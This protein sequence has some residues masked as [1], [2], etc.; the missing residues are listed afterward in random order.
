MEIATV[1]Q[2]H[3]DP[4]TVIDTVHS[5]FEYA[6]NNVLLLING[7][8]WNELKDIDL[9]VSKVK[10]FRHDVPKSP[11]RN[12]ALG[13]SLA[14]ENWDSDWFCYTEYDAI[15]ASDRFKHNLRMA[16][17]KGVWM[18]GNCGHV[19]ECQMPLVE[20]LIGE[21]FRS[22]YYLLGCCLFFHRDFM[23]KLKEINFFDRFLFLTNSFSEG[24]FPAYTGYDI[25][26]HMY[27]TLCR[28]F[29][30]NVGVFATWDEIKQEWH[31]AYEHFPMRWQPELTDTFPDA[32]I[33]HPLKTYNHPVRTFHRERRIHGR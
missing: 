32:S 21:K 22:V 28:H 29:G 12:M 2:V 26:E 23:S 3:S 6:T 27:P 20:S 10:G 7:S 18:L 24:Y 5:I 33:L 30:G 17:E 11:Y 31:G 15:F 13:L 9:N 25:S 19:D 1:L 4:D 14:C 8:S 16:E